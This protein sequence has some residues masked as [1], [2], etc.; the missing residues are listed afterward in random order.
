METFVNSIKK[1][2]IERQLVTEEQWPPVSGHK[3]INLQL[4]EADKKEGFCGGLP[5]QGAGGGKLKRT[6]ILLDDLFRVEEG[7]KPVRKVLV[8][9]NG[10]MGKST[11]CTML[12][13]G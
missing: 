10:G 3:L 13:E 2:Y 9:G 4:V 12:S 7:K 5:Q 1:T 8:E 6:P 11:L